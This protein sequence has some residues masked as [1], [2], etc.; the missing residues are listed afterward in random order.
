MLLGTYYTSEY[1]IRIIFFKYFANLCKH[2]NTI[3]V[4]ASHLTYQS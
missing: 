1:S 4:H 3:A 2:H